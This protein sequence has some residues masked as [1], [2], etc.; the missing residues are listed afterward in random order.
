[1]PIEPLELFKPWQKPKQHF[2][3]KQTAVSPE[4]SPAFLMWSGFSLLYVSILIYPLPTFTTDELRPLPQCLTHNHSTSMSDYLIC[5][6]GY[7]YCYTVSSLSIG[8]VCVYGLCIPRTL[9]HTRS[10]AICWEAIWTM[11]RLWSYVQILTLLM[12]SPVTWVKLLI[13]PCLHSLICKM[14]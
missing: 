10:A 5:S 4:M 7:F 9:L 11:V 3:A 12:I 8:T 1:M 2:G 13:S 14:G 6:R